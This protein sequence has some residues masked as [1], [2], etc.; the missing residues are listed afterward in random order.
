[1]PDAAPGSAGLDSAIAAIIE[2]L[3]EEEGPMTA[4][5]R[6]IVEA[7]V[8]C[9]AE[10]GYEATSTREIAQRAG[11]AEATIFRHFPT[12]KDLLL[13]LLRPLA[14]RILR[15]A[16]LDELGA[17]VR[18]AGGRFEPFA[19]AMM[20]NRLAFADRYAPLVRILM[21]EVLVDADVRDMLRAEGGAQILVAI[22]GTLDR[23]RRNGQLKDIPPERLMRFLGP[24]MLGYYLARTV[25]LPDRDW[26]DDA[27]IAATIDFFMHGAGATR[28]R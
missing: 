28:E 17:A 8:L 12:K 21:Q 24:L 25:I 7:A 16:A 1:M 9:F 5:K 10:R 23:F 3:A 19:M 20:R 15:P 2:A 13:R 11:V 18:D 14:A 27:E 4:R 26:D 22:A 6:R